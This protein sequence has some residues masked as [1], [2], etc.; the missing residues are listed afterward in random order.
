MKAQNSRSNF[1]T[2]FAGVSTESIG[3]TSPCRIKGI[4]NS[5]RDLLVKTDQH[6]KTTGHG[7]NN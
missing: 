2:A 1:L 6:H 7:I 3:V 5:M 4:A